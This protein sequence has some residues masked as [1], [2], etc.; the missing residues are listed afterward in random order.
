MASEKDKVGEA[1]SDPKDT[2]PA[3]AEKD[4]TSAAAEGDV[5][6]FPDPDEDDLD[7]L[8]G[9]RSLPTSS[10]RNDAVNIT[11]GVEFLDDFSAPK[12]APK[13]SVP[14]PSP[15]A[16]SGANASPPPGTPPVSAPTDDDL[17]ESLAKELEKG[18]SEFFSGLDK[19]VRLLGARRLSIY[20]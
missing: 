14:Q 9:K 11:R 19:N 8:D 17:D 4:K 16:A 7:D 2:I 1:T 20:R 15:G 6:D 13:T 10:V 18:F 12:P 5:E 3:Q